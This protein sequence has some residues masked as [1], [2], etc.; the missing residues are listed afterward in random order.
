MSRLGSIV[1]HHRVHSPRYSELLR[2]AGLEESWVPQAP[3]DLSSLPIIDKE[4]LRAAR[5]NECPGTDEPVTL[6]STSG[7]TSAAAEIPHNESSLRAG[8]GE[9][10]ARAL[11]LGNLT[12]DRWC[13]I[14]HWD[15][16]S[17]E[18]NVQVTGSFLSM[19]W[20]HDK[21]DGT[22]LLRNGATGMEQLADEVG[23]Y[24]PDAIASSPNLLAALA[25]TLLGNGDHL[26][27]EGLLYGGASANDEHRKLWHE[28]F[29]PAK[30]V[31]FYPTTDA[32][33]IG[34]S[35]KDNGRYLTFS[36]THLVEVVGCD[37]RHVK[38]GHRGRLGLC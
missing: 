15:P 3:E 13:L 36:E 9:N 20:L 29:A 31:A 18:R 5:F 38:E 27:L 34:V 26:R 35:P 17:T 37:G 21:L 19:A 24:R 11:V 4:F 6:V 32:G 1:M 2:E 28:V 12:P 23:E 22:P 30:I 8:L 14:G 7:T 16:A 10:F 33:A 25:R